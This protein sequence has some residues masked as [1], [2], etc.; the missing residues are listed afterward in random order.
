MRLNAREVRM[1]GTLEN[2]EKL[3]MFAWW[4][5]FVAEISLHLTFFSSLDLDLHFFLSL[6]LDLIFF[7]SLDKDLNF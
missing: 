2:L 4:G 1:K 7:L 5:P 6:D 3:N